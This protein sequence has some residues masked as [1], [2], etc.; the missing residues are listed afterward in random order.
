MNA[1]VSASSSGTFTN[2]VFQVLQCLQPPE[3]RRFMKFLH[4]PYFNQ[5]K[6]LSY[7]A[8]LLLAEIA[9]GRDGFDRETI[10]SQLSPGEGYDDVN[11]RKYCSDLLKLVERFFAQEYLEQDKS[12][13]AI[14][15]L[16]FVARRK[17][18]PLFNSALRQAK[19]EIERHDYRSIEFYHR[20]YQI[21][22]LY[23]TMMDFDVKIDVHFNIEKISNN[24]DVFYWIEKL[25]LYCSVLSQKRTGTFSY[26]VMFIEEVL[27]FLKTYP[28]DEVPELAIYY[29]AYL[30]LLDE[31]IENYYK[32]RD[33]LDKYGTLM[34][35]QEA[36]G[37]FDSALNYCIGKVNKGNRDFARE[38]FN[39]MEKALDNNIFIIN[40]EFAN[41]RY[42][43]VVGMAI[44]LGKLEWAEQFIE[45][46]K[47]M[48][49]LD[50]QENTYAFNLAR[51][52]RQQKKFDKVLRLLHNMEYEDISY[53][54][55]SKMM[56]IITYFE[57]DEVD[58]LE[59][60][61]ESFRVFLNRH[62][63][64]PQQ[65]RKSYLNFLKYVRRLNRLVPGDR[66]A[67]DKLRAEI[68]QDKAVTVN[69]DWLLEKL[70]EA[71]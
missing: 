2:K 60:L 43:N 40:E 14:D 55:I 23:Y 28:V 20:N 53:N 71:A 59:S 10:W 63:N 19:A 4:S 41:W 18:T 33:V 26:D 62:K 11:F 65:R 66:A 38:Y 1:P 27:E 54:L 13:Q 15:L 47:K 37:L 30:T 57:L 34:P 21:E 68:Q 49:P 48:L 17:V 51:V 50:T 61:T 29:Y 24:L 52:Y 22:R 58:A 46:Y 32:L 16:T 35:K 42:N 8:E 64:I 5:S 69:H 70:D 39:L 6:T 25:K 3:G 45:Q 36:T 12:R 31:N 44:L 67:V 9:E 56:L 7:L